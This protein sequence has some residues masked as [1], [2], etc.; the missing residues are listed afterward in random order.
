[1]KTITN[2]TDLA[3]LLIAL[4]NLLGKHGVSTSF[5]FAY[6]TQEFTCIK[7]EISNDVGILKLSVFDVSITA[8]C[9][10][11]SENTIQVNNLSYQYG[12]TYKG[13]TGCNIRFPEFFFR[14][15]YDDISYNII[16]DLKAD[17]FLERNEIEK[18]MTDRFEVIYTKTKLESKLV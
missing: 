17:K 4:E 18:Y 6:D 5:K 8:E 13:N 7:S 12:Q 1:M 14:N 2:T 15:R 10:Y 16:Y 9:T 3:N 11:H